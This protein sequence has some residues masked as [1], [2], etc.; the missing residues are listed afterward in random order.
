EYAGPGVKRW[1]AGTLSAAWRQDHCGASG[2]IDFGK[3][4]LLVACYDSN[5]VI[6][7]DEH[8]KTLRTLTRDNRGKP[9]IG[10]NDFAADGAGGV[11]LTASGVYALD[12]PITGAVLH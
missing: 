8:G 5:S 6:E 4:H 3:H 1:D 2:L 7:I 10:P 12:A 9:F 11:F